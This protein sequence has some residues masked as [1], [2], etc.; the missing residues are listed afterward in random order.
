MLIV[1]F[2]ILSNY[3]S[4][5]E[6]IF[7]KIFHLQCTVKE[8]VLQKSKQYT[9]DQIQNFKWNWIDFYL[10]QII[11]I[12]IQLKLVFNNWL[13]KR[14]KCFSIYLNHVEL[15]MHEDSHKQ[16]GISINKFLE[17][18]HYLVKVK[19]IIIKNTKDFFQ[20][21][22]TTFQVFKSLLKIRKS[23]WSDT[24]LSI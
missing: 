20:I 24:S 18:V 16:I 22:K 19:R 2:K 10:F 4:V 8:I 9:I 1:N 11:F 21:H 6:Q 7:L 15:K 12:H 13:E 3:L 23:Q 5:N 14:Q 17:S